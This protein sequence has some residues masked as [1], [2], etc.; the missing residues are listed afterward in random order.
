[1]CLQCGKG[2]FDTRIIW[3]TNSPPDNVVG[4]KKAGKS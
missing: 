4:I 2:E 1:M 3:Q